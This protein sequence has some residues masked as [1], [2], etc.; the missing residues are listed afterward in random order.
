MESRP[1]QDTFQ[2]LMAILPNLG[3][4][5]SDELLADPQAVALG[6]VS[7]GWRDV[8][9]VVLVV[10]RVFDL[11]VAQSVLYALYIQ[12]VGK[13]WWP[14][15]E[16]VCRYARSLQILTLLHSLSEEDCERVMG[17]AEASA[18]QYDFSRGLGEM[19]PTWTILCDLHS[20]L[21]SDGVDKAKQEVQ[22]RIEMQERH[23]PAIVEH[24]VKAVGIPVV[25]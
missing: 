19:N 8:P 24:L 17:H 20:A 14:E 22:F 11:S 3:E 9:Y 23:L 15:L 18:R 12:Q 1:D 16:A 7:P 10:A 5:P 2:R 4:P 21:G 25:A 13:P 6:A